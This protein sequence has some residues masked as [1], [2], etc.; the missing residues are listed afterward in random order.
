ML[1]G[2]VEDSEGK[3]F[4]EEVPE[5]GEGPVAEL[6]EPQAGG[7]EYTAPLPD[8]FGHA[9]TGIEKTG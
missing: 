7:R 6:A 3:H 1:P 8:N 5:I 4:A 9:S 2:A